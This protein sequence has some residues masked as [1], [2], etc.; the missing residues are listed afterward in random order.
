MKQT[1][2]AALMSAALLFAAPAAFAQEEEEKENN[3]SGGYIGIAGGV[4][5]ED[6]AEGFTLSDDAALFRILGGYRMENGVAV[7]LSYNQY[8]DVRVSSC[9]DNNLL[10]RHSLAL[11]ALYHFQLGS[12]FSVFPKVGFAYAQVD[13]GL[14]DGFVGSGCLGYSDDSGTDF[15]YGAG[16]E[17]RVTDNVALR[18]DIDKGASALDSENFAWSAGLSFY[19]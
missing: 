2:I 15:L 8:S 9:S 17:F 10:E 3:L 14:P 11:S 1:I 16:A 13:D 7:E 18:A 6:A 5:D 19:F 12:Q 4:M